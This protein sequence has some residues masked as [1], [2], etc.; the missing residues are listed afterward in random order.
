MLREFMWVGRGA[1]GYF[2]ASGDRG[3]F[4]TSFS[5]I[6]NNNN[7]LVALVLGGLNYL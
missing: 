1:P 5:H 2:H 3:K 6:S 4:L 7:V